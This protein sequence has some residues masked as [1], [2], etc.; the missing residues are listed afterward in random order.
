[1]IPLYYLAAMV[2]FYIWHLMCHTKWNTWPLSSMF[3]DHMEHHW[4]I[5]PPTKE[6]F[7]ADTVLHA[8]SGLAKRPAWV[9]KIAFPNIEHELPLYLMVVIIAV[10]G[11]YLGASYPTMACGLIYCMVA[12]QIMVYFHESFHVRHHPW[13]KYQWFE[14]L[15]ALH[16]QHH[17]GAAKTNFAMFNLLG[18]QLLGTYQDP[19][20]ASHEALRAAKTLS[21][22]DRSG[23]SARKVTDNKKPSVS[24]G[25]TKEEI[26]DD[27]N[28]RTQAFENLDSNHD[29]FIDRNEVRAALQKRKGQNV[30]VT[31][32]EVDS[33]MKPF[34][35]DGDGR[36]SQEEFFVIPA[37]VLKQL[38]NA[39]FF[40]LLAKV[41]LGL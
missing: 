33:M 9:K 3:A 31:E 28:Y 21:D 8:S 38:E 25:N 36:I 1:M 40:D 14:L 24:G 41:A 23:D 34:D 26:A 13:R 39:T 18:D 27:V 30:K 10:G 35:R 16:L 15:T 7:L 32:E 37:A 5:Y 17:K 12:G 19:T 4:V 29:G 22:A 20:N 11:R 6:K 2:A